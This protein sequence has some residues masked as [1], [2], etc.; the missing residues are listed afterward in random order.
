MTATAA[1]TPV[2]GHPRHSKGVSKTL[3]IAS[4]L[5]AM[6]GLIVLGWLGWS[7]LN[8]A[9]SPYYYELVTKG[10]VEQFPELGL[11][12]VPDI[13]VSKYE[14]L[15]NGTDKPLVVLY[16]GENSQV[17]IG[18]V[19]L[20]W[21]TQINEP[22]IAMEPSITE[23]STLMVAI[24]EHLPENALVLAWWDT[25]RRLKLLGNIDTL[26]FEH[27]SQPLLIPDVWRERRKSIENTEHQFWRVNDNAGS[28][29]KLFERFREALL[30]DKATGVAEL[31]ALVENRETYLVLH[32]TDAYKLGIANPE[33]VGIGYKDFP[34][35]GNLHTVS[36]HVKKWLK[37][38][39]YTSFSLEKR[40]ATSIRVYFLTDP[41]SADTLIAQALP[42]TTSKPF[43]IQELSVVYQSGGYWIYKLLGNDKTK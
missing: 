41:I 32:I 20:E 17:D 18:P 31:R 5:L 35:T 38:N 29:K 19:L 3:P 40:D 26:F 39:G 25:S 28:G 22:L 24:T 16:V 9:P 36:G 12:A 21:Q 15:S 42:F 33:Q 11:S 7:V 2:S 4:I 23:F 10:S 34:N 14:L 13:S 8:P 27:L 6:G 30:A 37:E 43:E 1:S